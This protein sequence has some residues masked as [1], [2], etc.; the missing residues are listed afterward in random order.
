MYQINSESWNPS[1]IRDWSESDIYATAEAFGI[2]R[3]RVTIELGRVYC[4]GVQIGVED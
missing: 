2:D 3:D 1:N 4:D